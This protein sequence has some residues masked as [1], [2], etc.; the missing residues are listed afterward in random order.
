LNLKGASNVSWNRCI[1][2][3]TLECAYG[4]TEHKDNIHPKTFDEFLKG[5]TNAQKKP[6]VK[7]RLSII[8]LN[9]VTTEQ[10]VFSIPDGLGFRAEKNKHRSKANQLPTHG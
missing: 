6:T 2:G 9:S 5:K 1:T 4:S 8:S 3:C 7:C 10:K